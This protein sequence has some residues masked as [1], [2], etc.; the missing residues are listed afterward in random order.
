MTTTHIA[1]PAVPAP[2]PFQAGVSRGKKAGAFTLVELLVAMAVMALLLVLMLQVINGVLISSRTQNQQMEA[3]SSARL[4]LDVMAV[5]LQRAVTGGSSAILVPDQGSSF[6]NLL[7]LMT[8]RLRPA[9]VTDASHRFLA[10]AYATNSA[11]QLFRSYG[12]VPFTNGNLIG[13]LPAAATNTPVEPLARGILAI[14]IVALG[15]G[16]NSYAIPSPAS[17][18]WATN[19]YNGFAVP[20][21]YLALLTPSPTFV[22]YGANTNSAF[23]SGLTNLTRALSVWVATVDDKNYRLLSN[24]PSLL[25]SAKG[26]LTSPDPTT[27]RTNIDAAAIP[28]QTKSAIRI[29][30]KTITVQ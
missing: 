18:N 28:A 24:A 11:N 6:T 13:S 12:S 3:T 2:I 8:M 9:G 1:V 21:G 16:T 17:A 30:T 5:D 26:A 14:R 22:A 20:G 15:D 25:A 4:A 23:P 7:S 10:V 27:W 19:N 29:L